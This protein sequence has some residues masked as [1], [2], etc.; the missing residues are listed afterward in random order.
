MVTSIQVPGQQGLEVGPGSRSW[1]W[2]NERPGCDRV[3]WDVDLGPRVQDSLP[4]GSR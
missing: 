1:E 3:D 4:C 2:S